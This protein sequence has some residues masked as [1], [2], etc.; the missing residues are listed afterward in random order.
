MAACSP[1]HTFLREA[2]L[3][4]LRCTLPTAASRP[5][6]PS[7]PPV[8]PLGP[9]AASAL[10]AV[11]LGDYAAALA[12]AVP[13]I[14]RASAST[15]ADHDSPAQFYGH[16]AAAAE[17]FVLWDVGGGAADEGF[18]CRCA[19]VL[20]AAAA[21]LL[22][23]TQQNVTG[24]PG[25]YPPLPFFISTSLDAGWYSDAGGK[26]DQWA[27]FDSHAHGKFVPFRT[28][29]LDERWYSDPGGKWE[30]WASHHLASFGS[31]VH[32]KFLLLQF[33]VFA[34]LLLTSIKSLDYDF[35]SVSWWLCRLSM[36]Q[37]NILDELSSS[38]FD[39]VQV[40]KNK[41]LAHFGELEMVSSYWGS[42]LGDGEGSSLVSAALLEAGLAEYKYGRVDASRLHLD[43]AQEVCGIHLSLTGILG[44]R[45]I[46]QVDA[47]SQMVLITKTTKPAADEGQTTEQRG[48]PDDVVALRKMRSS[49]PGESDEFCDI[50]R[51]PL[52]AE[53]VNDSNSGSTHISLT[54]VQQAAV[55]AQCLHVSRRSRGDEML[56]WE[57]APYIE[58]IDSQHDSCYAIRSLCD[59]LRIRWESTRSRTKQRALLM[60]ENL[61]EETNKEFP[62]ASERA[63]LVFGVHTPTLPALRKEYGELLISCG[64][65]GEAL[66]VF[67]DLELWDNLIYCYRLSGKV[68]D[69]VSL[70]NTRLSIT[71]N[72]PKLWCSLGDATNN[73]NYYKKAL[74]VSNNKSARALRS[75]ARSAYN[76]NDFYTSKYFWESALA[77]NSLYPDGWFAYGTTAWK[78]QD[79]EKALD[80][81]SR[82]VQIDPENGE[83]W[84]NIA[85]LHMIRGRSRASVQS[86]REAVKF[87][88]N[89]WQVW[90]NYSKVALDTHNIRLT[91][92][93][94]KM[95]LN[96]SSNQRFNVDLL[97]KVM[98][99]LEEQATHLNDTQEAKSI[100]N[101]S[102]DSNKEARQSSQLLDIIGD[103]LEQILNSGA[104]VPEICGLSARYHK[105]K[106][107]LEKCSKALRNQVQ[108]LKGSELWHDH[109]KFKKFAQASLQLCK[110]YME[111][112]STAGSKRELLLAEMHL[113]SSL[114]EAMDFVGSE[115][116]KELAD[117]LVELKDLIGAA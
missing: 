15:E 6:P 33:I 92:E 12:C 9:V 109:K 73:D 91:L 21:A 47:K 84:N 30:A 44:F 62:V 67:K 60:M 99:T 77:L 20:S 55:L 59:F 107:N 52:L 68:A 1:S 117:C 79:L 34:E 63:R 80:A 106:G 13:H 19:L 11:E 14:L 45:T 110:F 22:A 90:E 18:E 2:E 32:G 86:F 82:A 69:A 38:L 10:A 89:S 40:Y 57:M 103:I 104:S 16:L 83:A 26:Q 53:N 27:S 24:P 95:V 75:L 76:K 3:R 7:P 97:D 39:Q 85:C 108:Y 50:L 116:Y 29:S 31:H 74:D 23:F 56:G 8:H 78:D 28:S 66:N 72:D 51:T 94:I 64:L 65:L 17:V 54:L 46:H 112:S 4:L 87:K 111:I 43:S 37:Q 42:F 113:K 115:E 100:G 93:A 88:R 48:A 70:I 101:T 41:M 105:S 49:V 58:S 36:S 71:P 81:F 98:T 61:I 102:D 5:P 35:W 114:K 96:L 25:K